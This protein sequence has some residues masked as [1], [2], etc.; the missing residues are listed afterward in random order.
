MT[1]TLKPCPFCGGEPRL[2][3][4]NS[5]VG[6]HTI[7]C[8]QDCHLEFDCPGMTEAETINEWNTRAT[9][10]PSVDAMKAAVELE[11]RSA[12]GTVQTVVIGQMIQKAIDAALAQPGA[13]P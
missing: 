8:G 5:K 11:I 1:D 7:T 12:L 9:P 6:G 2:W 3:A 13:Q 4:Q 10:Y